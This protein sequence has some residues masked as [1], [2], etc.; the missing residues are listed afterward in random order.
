[1]KAK[2]YLMKFYI[3]LIKKDEFIMGLQKSDFLLQKEEKKGGLSPSILRHLKINVFYY[4]FMLLH[5]P[6]YKIVKA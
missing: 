5:I 6:T 2:N 1:M 3:Y 4:F